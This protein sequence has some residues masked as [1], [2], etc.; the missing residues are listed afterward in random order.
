MVKL[1]VIFKLYPLATTA[2]HAE[3][4]LIGLAAQ[5]TIYPTIALKSF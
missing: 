2:E 1:P 5:H 3:N 4:S